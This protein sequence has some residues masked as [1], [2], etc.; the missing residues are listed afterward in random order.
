MQ[1]KRNDAGEAVKKYNDR[2]GSAG[3]DGRKSRRRGRRLGSHQ[4]CSIVY[5]YRVHQVW[6]GESPGV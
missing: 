4:G 6:D 3:Y 5:I 1:K 2:V